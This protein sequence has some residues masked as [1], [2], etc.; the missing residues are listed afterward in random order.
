MSPNTIMLNLVMEFIYVSCHRQK[1]TFGQYICC[2]TTQITP[3]L[4]ILFEF[5]KRA[6]HL[7]T[8][9][10]TE[11]YTLFRQNPFQ[12]FPAIFFKLFC[13]RKSFAAFFLWNL[14]V[15][16]FDTVIFI[17]TAITFVTSVDTFLTHVSMFAFLMFHIF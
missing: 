7:D 17:R 13:N 10:Y 4:H 3:E 9:V 6:F 2:S 12:I 14:P 1:N 15:P 8:S 5:A 11:K 16:S